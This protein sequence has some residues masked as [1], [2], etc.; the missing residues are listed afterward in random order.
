MNG[1]QVAFG[2]ARARQ[3][4]RCQGRNSR[5]WNDRGP[6]GRRPAGRVVRAFSQLAGLTSWEAAPG[7][8][9]QTK[10]GAPRACPDTGDPVGACGWLP[11]RDGLGELVLVR[12][13]MPG[14]VNLRIQGSSPSGPLAEKNSAPLTKARYS[15]TEPSSPG[16][17]SST[18]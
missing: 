3:T 16:R 6:R 13:A 2:R 15:G 4:H 11:S 14:R 8:K 17:I 1:R 9:V 18:R 5:P 7:S 10:R 12:P